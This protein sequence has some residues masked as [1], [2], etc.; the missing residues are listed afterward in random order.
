MHC[1][2]PLAARARAICRHML[3]EHVTCSELVQVTLH[4]LS[5]LA[6]EEVFG[7]ADQVTSLNRQT[8]VEGVS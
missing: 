1:D 5:K 2:P 4:S 8:R 6:H 3:Q 7:I